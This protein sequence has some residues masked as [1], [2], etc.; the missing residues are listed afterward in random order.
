MPRKKRA[1]THWYRPEPLHTLP[2]TLSLVIVLR[3]KID[4]SEV[5]QDS[6]LPAI[7]YVLFKG[8]GNRLLLGF[9]VA[10]AARLLNKIVINPLSWAFVCI[11]TQPCVFRGRIGR[12]KSRETVSRP[13][14]F[15]YSKIEGYC[16]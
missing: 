15:L 4:G 12:K 11:V 1:T 2:A 6:Q 14:P 3:V 10:H 16:T 7:L 5:R 8:S 9:V 13:R